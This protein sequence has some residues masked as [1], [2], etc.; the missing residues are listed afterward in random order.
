M[1]AITMPR[2][3]NEGGRVPI[4]YKGMRTMSSAVA[5]TTTAA[6]INKG[7]RRTGLEETGFGLL[8][9][10]VPQSLQYLAF[11]ELRWSLREQYRTLKLAPHCVQKLTC[12]EKY[13]LQLRQ[14][15][16]DGTGGNG[17]LPARDAANRHQR[18]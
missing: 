9:S 11:I 5:A 4:K 14:Y 12:S 2:K 10:D 17:V 3:T 8:R 1:A 6:R 18:V 7:N 13:S 16:M 15:F